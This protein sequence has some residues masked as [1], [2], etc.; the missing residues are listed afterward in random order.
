VNIVLFA[1]LQCSCEWILI[2]YVAKEFSGR[3][4]TGRQPLDTLLRF[5]VMPLHG[6][7][8]NLNSNITITYY[9]TDYRCWC[10]W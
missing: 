10:M 8:F 6:T 1:F 5:Q 2:I 9:A 7:F 4:R 3:F